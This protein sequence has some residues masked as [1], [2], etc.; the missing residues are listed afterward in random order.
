MS[1][2]KQIWE[3]YQNDTDMVNIL[4]CYSY[5]CYKTINYK[6]DEDNISFLSKIDKN[7][8]CQYYV[9]DYVIS[10]ISILSQKK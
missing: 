3:S 5:N 6:Y 7:T 10:T 9:K 1:I 4:P 2:A 8:V